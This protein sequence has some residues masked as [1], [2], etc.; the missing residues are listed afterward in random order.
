VLGT[1]LPWAAYLRG[2]ADA[3]D[4]PMLDRTGTEPIDGV[5]ALEAQVARLRAGDR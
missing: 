3:L 1:I 5:A 4:V 2:H